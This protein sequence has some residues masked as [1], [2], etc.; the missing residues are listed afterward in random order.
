[1]FAFVF[2]F[3]TKTSFKIFFDK[4]LLAFTNKKIYPERDRHTYVCM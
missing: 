4:L 1:M 2:F 3:M